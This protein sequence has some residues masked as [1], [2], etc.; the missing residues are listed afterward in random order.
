MDLRDAQEIR[1]DALEHL[2]A[3][4]GRGKGG[5]DHACSHTLGDRGARGVLVVRWGPPGPAAQG[6]GAGAGVVALHLRVPE[7]AEAS[8]ALLSASVL[9]LR[10]R[11]RA[12]VRLCPEDA[13]GAAQGWDGSGWLGGLGPAGPERG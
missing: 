12:V 8:R 3:G 11:G 6:G 7:G 13:A 10:R 2:C 5:W 4:L 1:P 9:K